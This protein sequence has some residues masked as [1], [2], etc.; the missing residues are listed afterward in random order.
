MAYYY[1]YCFKANTWSFWPSSILQRTENISGNVPN[2]LLIK[3][4]EFDL[5]FKTFYGHVPRVP[6][7][8]EDL[9]YLLKALDNVFQFLNIPP[10]NILLIT[11]SK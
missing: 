5:L 11:L 7:C 2:A 4:M 10:G 9:I 8:M 1:R 3:E 6:G